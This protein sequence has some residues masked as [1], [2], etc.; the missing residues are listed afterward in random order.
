MIRVMKLLFLGNKTFL[1]Q[2]FTCNFSMIC[3]QDQTPRCSLPVLRFLAGWR[4]MKGMLLLLLWEEPLLFLQ[5]QNPAPGGGW[6]SASDT[7][8]WP[9]HMPHQAFFPLRAAF[10]LA[11]LITIAIRGQIE[12]PLVNQTWWKRPMFHAI[13]QRPWKTKFSPFEC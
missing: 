2:V 1:G 7:F 10:M 6:I 3:S 5:V 4:Q 11:Q 9:L 12:S 13:A 8:C